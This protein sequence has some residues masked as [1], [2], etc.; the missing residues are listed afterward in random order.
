MKQHEADGDGDDQQIK[1]A[2][3]LEG[4]GLCSAL[5][6]VDLADGEAG[7]GAFVAFAAGLG[8][9]LRVHRALGIAR[10]KDVVHAVTT[11]AIGHSL[12][13]LPG[14]QTMEGGVEADQPVARH[15]ELARQA[16]VSVAASAGVADVA[17]IHR[18]GGV[19]ML[20]DLVLAVAI[21]AQ[22]RL[23]DAPRQSLAMH[24]GAKLF[25]RSEEHTSELQSPMY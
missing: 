11:G 6:D 5:A 15:T 4:F 8:Q 12:R 9:V 7:S 3:P 2:H 25:Y 24:A 18:T 1:L 16:D 22:R 21:G 14:G 13:A 20:E 19:G 17:G 10:S 23:G